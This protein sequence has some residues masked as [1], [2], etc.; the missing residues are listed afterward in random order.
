MLAE[1]CP[2]PE[3]YSPLMWQKAERKRFCPV[4]QL[5]VL[6]GAFL[7]R[8]R[9]ALGRT[10]AWRPAADAEAGRAAGKPQSEAVATEAQAESALPAQPPA[11]QV[12]QAASDAAVA[13][14]V[15]AAVSVL[16][17]RI[18]RVTAAMQ[19]PEL[20][21]GER[22]AVAF[23]TECATAIKALREL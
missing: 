13:Q 3:C 14:T 19:D 21:D 1:A 11:A 7:S 9:S 6:T 5:Y 16:L 2:I 23:I 10:H 22:Q 12:V 4:H 18:D 8:Y 17:A 15:A 20:T